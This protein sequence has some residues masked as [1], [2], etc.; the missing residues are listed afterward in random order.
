MKYLMKYQTKSQKLAETF[1]FP[2]TGTK[3][4]M[5]KNVEIKIDVKM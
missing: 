3:A 2:R 1:H 4:D 5:N